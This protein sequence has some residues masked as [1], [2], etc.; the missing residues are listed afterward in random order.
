MQA[1][2]HE[3]EQYLELELVQK[4]MKDKTLTYSFLMEDLAALMLLS[5]MLLKDMP[6]I[7]VRHPTMTFIINNHN[8]KQ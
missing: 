2:G 8:I 4:H 5:H 6:L 1:E 7:V 3:Q